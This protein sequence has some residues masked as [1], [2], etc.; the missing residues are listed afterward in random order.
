MTGKRGSN[1][2]IWRFDGTSG[3]DLG[4]FIPDGDSLPVD[5][6]LQVIG[7]DGNLYISSSASDEVLRYDGI[8]GEFIGSF[9]F[10]GGVL[11]PRG[12]VFVPEPGT[13]A[14]LGAGLAGLVAFTRRPRPGSRC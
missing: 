4:S 7:P 14:L 5:P 6:T 8:S 1:G 3:A 12:L 10:G 13:G 9:A 2:G 11:D